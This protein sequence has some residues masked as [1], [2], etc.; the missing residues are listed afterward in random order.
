MIY[1][2]CQGKSNGLIDTIFHAPSV[3]RFVSWQRHFWFYSR[4]FYGQHHK[5]A[6]RV[7]CALKTR[8]IELRNGTTN[9][10]IPNDQVD[11]LRRALT[12]FACSDWGNLFLWRFARCKIRI[13]LPLLS[14]W[15]FFYFLFTTYYY[16]TLTHFH[17]SLF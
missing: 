10:T 4:N 11:T 12:L 13:N 1:I 5:S 2:G 7:N 8:T 3:L 6:R 17:L 14:L 16:L 9:E 15:Y